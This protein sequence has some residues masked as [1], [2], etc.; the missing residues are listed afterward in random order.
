M[1]AKEKD[2]RSRGYCVF[3]EKYKL[4]VIRQPFPGMLHLTWNLQL[5]TPLI[6]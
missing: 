6:T 4:L 5:K 1:V 2:I 3:N